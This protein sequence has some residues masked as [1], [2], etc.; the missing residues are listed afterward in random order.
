MVAAWSN[1]KPYTYG[2]Y[3]N[4]AMNLLSECCASRHGE[5]Y[6]RLS[7]LKRKYDPDNT[8]RLNQNIKPA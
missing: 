5:S 6:A 8:F 4:L 3:V 7:T 1:V 2:A